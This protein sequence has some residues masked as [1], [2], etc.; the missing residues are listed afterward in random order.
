MLLEK[1]ETFVQDNV[2]LGKLWKNASKI[3]TLSDFNTS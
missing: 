2:T 1:V 3:K